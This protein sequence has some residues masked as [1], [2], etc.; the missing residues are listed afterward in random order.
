MGSLGYMVTQV[1]SAMW[2]IV[3][4]PYKGTDRLPEAFMKGIM[5]HKFTYQ[6]TERMIKV[7]ADTEQST[8]VKIA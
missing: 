8:S 5:F 7:K 4:H 1:K 6:F 3:D 2:D